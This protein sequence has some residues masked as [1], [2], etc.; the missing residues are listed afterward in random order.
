MQTELPGDAVLPSP[1]P[2]PTVK[3]TDVADLISYIHHTLGFPP[4]NSLTAISLAGRSLG[5]VLRC[6]WDRDAVVA[7]PAH[8]SYARQF[9][10]HLASDRRADGCVAVLFR[11]GPSDSA[12][13]GSHSD[14]A[15]TEPLSGEPTSASDRMLAVALE[16]ELAEAGLPLKEMWLVT[17]GR[18]WHVDCPHPAACH[19]HGTSVALVETSVINASL[20]LEGSVVSDE[21]QGSGLPSPAPDFSP[22]LLAAVVHVAELGVPAPRLDDDPD[23][24]FGPFGQYLPGDSED[25]E[26]E[27]LSDWLKDW[28]RVLTG[29][30]LP[31]G[32]YARSLLAAGLM[33]V[34]W[35][36]C[37]LASACFSLER[38][39]S[40]AAWLGTVP[41]SVAESL[42]TEPR[43]VNGVLFTSV[44]LAASRRGPDWERLAHL[45]TACAGLLPEVTGRAASV[46][47]CLAAWV[48]W[49]RGR[50]SAAGRI[51]EECRLDDPEYSLGELLG[52]IVDR[53]MLSG[54]AGRR[55]T[56][57]SATSRW[58]G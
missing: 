8:S 43:E 28:D 38:A 52:E 29:G 41:S 32:P 9:A 35:R 30:T 12:A 37:L 51:L 24:P 56:A 58:T 6:D 22:E 26:S 4:R 20:I 54:W 15:A 17:Q 33:R 18:A 39:V 44:I 27:A 36:D 46:L 31:E 45:W 2:R 5:A 7:W 40:G 34:T 49:A 42:G 16:R 50:G 23:E 53:G 25:E 3:A 13:A 10:A 55:E 21:P 1:T 48:E 47:R 57:W 19:G 11:D 14:P